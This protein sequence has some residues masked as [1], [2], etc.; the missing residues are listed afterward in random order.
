MAG[1]ARNIMVRAGADFSAI[2]K[3]AQQASK[4]MKKMSSSIQASANLISK[5]LSALGIGVALSSIVSAANEAREAYEQQAEAEAKLAKAMQNTMGASAAEV[6]SIKDLC[7]AQQELG[8]IGDEVQM[9]G[10]QELATYLEQTSTLKKLIPVMNDMAA[11]QYGYN[12]TAESTAS[13]ATMLGKVMNGQVNALSRYG[14]KFD[15]AQEKVLKYGNEA[16]R[17]AVLAD[18]VSQSVGG[19]N[20]A[21]ANTPTGRMKQL[22]NTISDIKEQF[23]LAVTTIGTAFLPLLTKVANVLSSIANLATRVAQSIANVFGK[24][25]EKGAAAVSSGAGTAAVNAQAMADALGDVDKKAKKAGDS[26]K[27]AARNLMSFDELNVLS[28]NS[29]SGSTAA[30]EVEDLSD[31]LEDLS[32][33]TSLGTLFDFSDAVEG[34]GVLENALSKLRDAIGPIVDDIKII[35]GGLYDFIAGVF[36]G[37]WD[38]AFDGLS[39]TVS[40]FGKLVSDVIGNIVVPA[41]DGLAGQVIKIIG[42]LF[43]YIQEKTGVDLSKIKENVLYSLNFIRYSV[44]GTAIKIGW[45]VQDLC[46]VAAAI[47]K[48]DWNAAWKAAEKVVEDAMIDITPTVQQLAQQTTQEMMNASQGVSESSDTAK[49][50]VEESSK[51]IKDALTQVRDGAKDFS[52]S[53]SDEMGKAG[54][55]APKKFSDYFM[56]IIGKFR[57]NQLVRGLSDIV[58]AARICLGLNKK[59]SEFGEMGEESGEGYKE[60]WEDEFSSSKLSTWINN[61]FGGL[62]K[63]VKSFLK[64]G[65]P[66]KVFEDIGTNTIAGFYNGCKDKFRDVSNLF[67]GFANDFISFGK[68]MVT[69]LQT[70]FASMWSSFSSAVSTL[71]SSLLS[72]ISSAIQTAFASLSSS[73]SS[74]VSSAKTTLSNFAD[75][76][77]TSINNILSSS[78][79]SLNNIVS[80]VQTAVNGIISQANSILSRLRGRSYA[81]GGMV[82]DGLFYANHNELVGKFSNGKTAVANNEQITEGIKRAVIEGMQTVLGGAS[83]EETQ[84]YNIYIGSDLLYS[85]YT[86]YSKRQQLISG[87]RA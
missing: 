71:V 9:A 48:G 59:K 68:N 62:I 64:I 47:I 18:V 80:N 55:A 43:D 78:K 57:Q 75:S 81:T 50:A 41:F 84:P 4:S 82:E 85:G 24:K 15:E 56:E 36:T 12:A 23:G 72:G 8:I 65:S 13:I 28:D 66:S 21:L 27:K 33:E 52:K 26:A 74:A 58:N 30:D 25:L 7:A 17:A 79:S 87:G 46:D 73:V 37:D 35:F 67:K 60:G 32:D 16:Q 20:E 5:A 63:S 44:E 29:S 76:A 19:M 39:R 42:G 40:G 86:K 49:A 69:G 14:Y 45:I 54:E 2:T 34:F 83:G 77:R 38:R 61:T 53:F 6:K 22:K 11:Q 3:Q 51:G 70:G 10:A 31:A 1:A